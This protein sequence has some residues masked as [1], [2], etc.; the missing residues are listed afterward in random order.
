M[1]IIFILLTIYLDIFGLLLIRLDGLQGLVLLGT[2]SAPVSGSGATQFVYGYSGTIG[3]NIY[4][5]LALNRVQTST[6]TI[7]WTKRTKIGT[8][9]STYA[10]KDALYKDGYFYM[11]GG[12][13]SNYMI[14]SSTD[15]IVWKLRTF[16]ATPESGGLYYIQYLDTISKYCAL[17]YDHYGLSTDA[18]H[19][20]PY[21]NLGGQVQLTPLIYDNDFK[22]KK[23]YTAKEGGNSGAGANFLYITTDAIH[24]TAQDSLY[25]DNISGNAQAISY[26]PGGGFIRPVNNFRHQISEIE[27][28]SYVS[29]TSIESP[30][31]TATLN[32]DRYSFE[33]GNAYN[34]KLYFPRGV[35]TMLI[36]WAMGAPGGYRGVPGSSSGRSAHSSPLYKTI[37][38]VD[39]SYDD[40]R[41]EYSIGDRNYEN[42]GVYYASIKYLNSN[43]VSDV[44]YTAYNMT[45][46]ISPRASALGLTSNGQEAYLLTYTS[47]GLASSIDGVLSWE[48]RTCS[49][50]GSIYAAHCYNGIF[51]IANTGGNTASST[52]TIHWTKR[53]IPSMSGV[54][55][56]KDWNNLWRIFYGNSNYAVSTDAIVWTKRTVGSPTMNVRSGAYDSSTGTTVLI[57]QSRN[58]ASSTDD[59]HWTRR[60]AGTS[61]S[62][63]AQWNSALSNN[64]GQFIIAGT[65]GDVQK[66]T[67]AIIWTYIDW[68]SELGFSYEGRNDNSSGSTNYYDSSEYFDGKFY[69]SL[70][71]YPGYYGRYY[72]V[73]TTT[74]AIHWERENLGD[75]SAQ[76]LYDIS[77]SD[78]LKTI[79]VAGPSTNYNNNA[80][81]T[82]WRVK[83]D[84]TQMTSGSL[85][86]SNMGLSD[87]QQ[88]GIESGYNAGQY[89]SS[90]SGVSDGRDGSLSQYQQDSYKRSPNDG[91]F[92]STG[93][94]GASKTGNGGSISKKYYG[95]TQTVS[96]GS[97]NLTVF[98]LTVTHNGSGNYIISGTDQTTTHNNANNPTITVKSGNAIVFDV[99]VSGHP[100]WIKTAQTIGTNNRVPSYIAQNNSAQTGKITFNTQGLSAG[101]Y[102]Y[103]CQYHSSMKG[104]INVTAATSSFHG[105]DG[106]NNAFSG[107]RFGMGGGGGAAFEQ[108]PNFWTRVGQSEGFPDSNV[109]GTSS[110]S[111]YDRM[112]YDSHYNFYVYG[113][114]NQDGGGFAIST[115]VIHWVL[116]TV[117]NTSQTYG[118]FATN[119][120]G[121]YIL[122]GNNSL[123]G[124]TDTIH[125]ALRTLVHNNSPYGAVY[126]AGYYIAQAYSY[127]MAS[128]D[129]IHWAYRTTG[130]SGDRFNNWAVG[131]G[132]V[133]TSTSEFA[134]A[135][136]S[137]TDTIH[138]GRRTVSTK[139]GYYTN[140]VGFAG[141][142]FHVTDGN[143]YESYNISTDSI[144]WVLR[145]APN[146]RWT[147]YNSVKYGPYLGENVY[148][149][150]IQ[151]GSTL[152]YSTDTIHWMTSNRITLA[153]AGSSTQQ[154]HTLTTKGD[155]NW[156]YANSNGDSPSPASNLF[157]AFYEKGGDELFNVGNGGDAGP[158]CS[159]GGGGTTSKMSGY[160]GMGGQGYIQVTWW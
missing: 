40:L 66:S 113:G 157:R 159:G 9:S 86:A 41:L 96:G 153:S 93:A 100:F 88:Y 15:G 64:N 72:A 27:L 128:T 69:F 134:G 24:W 141:G 6:D 115:D 29:E 57:G 98:N 126:H 125:W 43:D 32:F 133:M 58:I 97:N 19:W 120:S 80:G 70:S 7:H 8:D 143:G 127:M 76:Y 75:N 55:E 78:D 4:C 102:Y 101:T 158:G 112:E 108:A 77:Y 30:K 18:I 5:H 152:G 92:L 59:I 160:G 21:D 12:N 17:G 51:F 155:G 95:S 52:D 33:G 89:A 148:F 36:E 14:Q 81:E 20:T 22:Q 104:T 121:G 138:W 26:K 137:S 73:M 140:G 90:V 114:Y 79:L 132:Y 25:K 38:K 28:K 34:R 94:S 61:Y 48:K 83:R 60:T 39:Q 46:L 147:G 68:M 42:G 116:R 131:N 129:T 110:S 122:Q 150:P 135:I 87:Y 123:S 82:S 31:G 65:Y 84:G 144:N 130:H 44:G 16:G 107:D 149:I 67:D 1:Q 117:G 74:D 35:T 119:G 63:N 11:A 145:T 154:S 71:D 37:V 91:F 105:S 45:N 139:Y 56:I 13:S 47:G 109:F 3:A 54:Y 118:Y 49:I 85:Q 103:I 62:N 146:I 53:T 151:S 23:Y 111:T 142:L 50:S 2:Y 136:I 106:T 99:N 124:S 156:Y 10:S